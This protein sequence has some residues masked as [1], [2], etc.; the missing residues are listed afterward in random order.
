MSKENH[1]AEIQAQQWDC[2]KSFIEDYQT[3]TFT[4]EILINLFGHIIDGLAEKF[5]EKVGIN[6]IVS[7]SGQEEIEML[8]QVLE[9]QAKQIRSVISKRRAD[10][11]QR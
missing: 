9:E 2:I 6:G 4:K 1:L 5:L 10:E 11:H 3:P 8:L 7:V